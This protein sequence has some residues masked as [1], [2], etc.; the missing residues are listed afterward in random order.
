MSLQSEHI[1]D[2]HAQICIER[3]GETERERNKERD[4]DRFIIRKRTGEKKDNKR[5]KRNTTKSQKKCTS[6]SGRGGVIV[7][8]GGVGVGGGGVGVGDY[9]VTVLHTPTPTLAER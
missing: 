4:S 9:T 6:Y 2:N 7:G 1:V 3:D 8:G 5:K